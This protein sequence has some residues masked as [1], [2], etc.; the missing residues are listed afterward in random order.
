MGKDLPK[1]FGGCLCIGCI[2][3]RIGRELKPKDFEPYHAFNDMPGTTRLM[4]RR[5]AERDTNVTH[6]QKA[7]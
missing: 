7:E 5:V 1:A 2:E 3:K 6:D 4:K